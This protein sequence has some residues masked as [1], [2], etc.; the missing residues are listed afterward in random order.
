MDWNALAPMA[1][2][3]SAGNVLVQYDQAYERYDT[4]NPQQLA[5]D[6]A[7]TP[8]GL[9][10]PGVLRPAPCPNVPL[11]PHFDEAWPGPAAQPGLDR[12]PGVL[13]G[14]R[15]P[16]DRPDRVHRHPP[17]GGRGRLGHRQRRLGRA[18]W[19][20]TRPSST[21]GPSTPTDH[22]P[23]TRWAGRPT[24][25]SPTPTAS[26]GSS[27]TPSTRTPG[28]P[29]RP[30]SRP[31]PPIR[32]TTRSTSSPGRP[33]DA[34]TTAVFQGISS[35]TASSYGSSITYLPEDQPAAALD[36]NPRPRGWTDSFGD[37]RRPVVAG[38]PRPSPHR[39]VAASGPTPDRRPRPV[40]HPGHP[41][42]RRRPAGHGGARAR[43]RGSRAARR[44]PSPPGRSPRCASP[45]PGLR[46]DPRRRPG[47]LAELGRL[48]RSGDPRDL[49]A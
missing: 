48:R 13:H 31:T 7:V 37:P 6:L 15:S 17:G 23:R 28:T 18:C 9:I 42:L 47:R 49:R 10:R 25:W 46:T 16:P 43:R 5:A 32:A 35:V 40:D 41:D 30:P 14:G 3:M 38:R 8:A 22:W 29:R 21:P 11:I 33:A 45:S 36:G 19:P 27:G 24:W 12:S 44:S 20:A 39:D 4:P 26:R 34:Q 2:L 1:S